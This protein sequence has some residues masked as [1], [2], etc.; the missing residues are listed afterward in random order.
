M[1]A[2][3]AASLAD[4]V[5]G[6]TSASGQ[7]PDNRFSAEGLAFGK[8]GDGTLEIRI[9]KFEA[10]SL[11]LASGPLTLEV[12]QVVLHQLTARVR[13]EGGSPRLST[14]EAASAELSDVK[15]QGP[16]PGQ[17][18][19]GSWSLDA[20]ATAD[21]VINAEILDATL[22]FDA[23]VKV[24][25]RQGLVDFNEAT[26]EHVG[27]DSRMGVSRLGIY[28]DAP[29]GR[30][31]L[32]QFPSALV[33]GVEYERRSPLP[34]PWG[35]KRGNLR[36]QPFGEELLRQ[37]PGGHGLGITEQ[38]RLLF[39][40]TAVSGHVQLGDGKFAAPGLQ[41]DL[42]GRAAGHN[43]VRLRSQAVGRGLDV[44][45]ASLSVRNAAVSAGETRLACDHATGALV[46]Q[47]L[48]E[49]KELRVAINLAKM[50]LSG[51]RLHLP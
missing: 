22:L 43:V 49:G 46:L 6:L 39:D 27:P 45:V 4:F 32:Y 35:T 36:L 3:F 2:A 33:T 28:V 47:F 31:Y 20:L 10:A 51:L 16:V 25:I 48:V 38:A 26:V 7:D 17:A 42:F 44:D 37:A 14:L 1:P 29:N 19:A 50:N 9:R 15:V 12:G 41:A 18:P 8:G 30:S 21:G 34:G 23:D 5:L 24:P 11:R 13:I 40:R